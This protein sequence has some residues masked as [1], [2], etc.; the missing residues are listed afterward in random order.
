[1]ERAVL[2]GRAAKNSDVPRQIGIDDRAIAKGHRYMILVCN[3]QEASVGFIGE[4]RKETSLAAYFDAFAIESREAIRLDMWPA[5]I[6]AC[7]DKVPGVDSKMVFDRFHIM[8]YV[9]EAVD[10]VRKLEHK[11]LMQAGDTTLKITVY[12]HGDF[13]LYPATVTHTKVG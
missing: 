1:M 5:Y 4:D 12:F 8:R 7:W 6:N 13:K 11:V 10:K 9:G 2:H 3:L